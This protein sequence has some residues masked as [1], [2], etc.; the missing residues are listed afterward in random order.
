MI[1]LFRK[2]TIFFLLMI[3]MLSIISFNLFY[4][5]TKSTMALPTSNK[6]IVI[7]PGHGGIDPGAVGETGVS[8]K[9]INLNIALKL[10]GYLENGGSIVVLTRSKD[11][12][13]NNYEKIIKHNRKRTDL[14]S[15]KEIADASSGDIFISIHLNS[16]PSDNRCKGAQVF[17]VSNSEQS[18]HLAELIQKDIKEITDPSSRREALVKKDAYIMKNSK[19]PTII[20]ECGFLSNPEE[21]KLLSSEE[22]QERIAWGIYC[23]ITKYMYQQELQKTQNNT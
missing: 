23:G 11:E 10:Q 20:I 19:M 9:S 7:D 3:M 8:E 16:F 6:V 12:L 14:K 5:D 18:K 22:Y 1:L 15:R 21:E 17:Y 2:K 4:T 13:V